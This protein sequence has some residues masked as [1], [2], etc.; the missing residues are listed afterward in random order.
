MSPDTAREV[1]STIARSDERA[2]VSPAF[3]AETGLTILFSAKESLFKCLQPLVR[4]WFDFLDAELLGLASGSG[5]FALR[6][7][8]RLS[9]EFDAGAC[10]DGRFV[11]D[12]DFVHTGIALPSDRGR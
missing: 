9:D 2:A 1:G 4:Q 11:V 3:D 5:H 10:F 7:L 8:K 12:G 6:L